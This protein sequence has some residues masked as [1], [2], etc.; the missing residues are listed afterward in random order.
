MPVST[1]FAKKLC[2]DLTVTILNGQTESSAAH[3]AGT[4]L[5]AF[6]I[7]A[8]FAG[9]ALTFKVSTDGTNYKTYK[10]MKD[11]AAVSAVV[12]ADASYATEMFDFVGYEW[13]KLVAGTSQTGDIDIQLKTRPI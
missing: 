2:A 3:L 8:G 4:S 13:I 5:V 7:P 10:R 6:D 12:G 1:Q 9:T 11:G